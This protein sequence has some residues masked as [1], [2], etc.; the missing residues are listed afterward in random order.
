MDYTQLIATLLPIFA[1]A[2]PLIVADIAKLVHGNPQAQGEADA[3]YIA[4]IGGLIDQAVAAVK[5]D[6]ANIQK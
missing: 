2:G 1:Q 4:R 5:A 3:A 6:D